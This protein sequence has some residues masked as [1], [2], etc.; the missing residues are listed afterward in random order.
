MP[1]K[2]HDIIGPSPTDSE[3]ELLVGLL[4][5]ASGITHP[6]IT[7]LKEKS[8]EERVR[9]IVYAAK[10][11]IDKTT[12]A[13]YDKIDGDKPEFHIWQQQPP[14]VP[15]AVQ[16]LVDRLGQMS[17]NG[18]KKKQAVLLALDTIINRNEGKGPDATL[19]AIK[20]A[21]GDKNSALYK[22]LNMKRW[23]GFAFWEQETG[24]YRAIKAEF[25]RIDFTSASSPGAR[26]GAGA[27]A[28]AA[29]GD[30]A[31]PKPK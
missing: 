18:D 4:P 1:V 26:A 10:K 2:L 15:K 11:F 25:D 13:N 22:A 31:G 8:V 21:L 19:Q 28:A 20:S 27:G 24:S 17:L 6:S 16:T 9:I 7:F 3:L 29:G 30:A 14:T 23:G 5:K 12:Q